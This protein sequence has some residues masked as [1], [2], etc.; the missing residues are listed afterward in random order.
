MKQL[1]LLICLFSLCLSLPAHGRNTFALDFQGGKSVF[2]GELI[3]LV[4]LIEH[5][6]PALRG[7]RITDIRIYASTRT[8]RHRGYVQLLDEYRRLIS[9][10]SLST[11]YALL[12]VYQKDRKATFLHFE[13]DVYLNRIEITTRGYPTGFDQLR[14]ERFGNEGKRGKPRSIQEIGNFIKTNYKAEVKKFPLPSGGFSKI[15]FRVHIG[16]RHAVIVNS[17]LVL[18]HQRKLGWKT[19]GARLARGNNEFT[20]DV[21]EEATDIQVSFAHGQGSSIQIFLLP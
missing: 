17:I 3:Y 16:E 5:R 18:S 2:A 7:E 1:S 15:N 14:E 8:G 12:P 20:L 21:P 9:E 19:I 13:E 11:G 10:D 4:D 6:A